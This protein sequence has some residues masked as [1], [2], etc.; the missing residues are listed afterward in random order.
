MIK[1]TPS[2]FRPQTSFSLKIILKI[3]FKIS[4][5]SDAIHNKSL[6]RSEVLERILVNDFRLKILVYRQLNNFWP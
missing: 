1:T 6:P 3:L 4:S 2:D 5:I